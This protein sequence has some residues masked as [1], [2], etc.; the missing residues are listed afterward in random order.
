MKI[1]FFVQW[2]KQVLKLLLRSVVSNDCMSFVFSLASTSYFVVWF[3]HSI[4]FFLTWYFRRKTLF[5][6]G[7]LFQA[8]LKWLKKMASN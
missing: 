4:C 1:H 2:E 6:V 8:S 7:Q 5:L 3:A